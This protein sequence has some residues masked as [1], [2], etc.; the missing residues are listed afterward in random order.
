[1]A[2]KPIL[3]I[4]CINCNKHIYTMIDQPPNVV[5]G[6]DFRLAND[7]KHHAS[8]RIECPVCGRF[9]FTSD[10]RVLTDEGIECPYTWFK[11]KMKETIDAE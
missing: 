5:R 2:D 4:L 7:E 10:F 8:G 1:M 6:A 3:R 11:I 9:P